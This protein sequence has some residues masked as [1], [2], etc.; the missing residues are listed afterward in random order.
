M[1]EVVQTRR[2]RDE[3]GRMVESPVAPFLGP[4]DLLVLTGKIHNP[5]RVD[6]CSEVL[7]V[8]ESWESYVKEF[9]RD[10]NSW[11]RLQK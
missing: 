10:T 11:L 8:F 7:P 6:K 1:D 9:E 3:Q 4:K 5:K 2:H